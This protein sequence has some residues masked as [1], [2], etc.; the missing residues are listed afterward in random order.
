MLLKTMIIYRIYYFGNFT[1]KDSYAIEILDY[2]AKF[3]DKD[4]KLRFNKY[5]GNLGSIG[6]LID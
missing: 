4:L 1:K 3:W 2:T 5:D 6:T